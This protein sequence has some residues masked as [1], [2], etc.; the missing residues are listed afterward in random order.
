[1]K[2]TQNIIFNLKQI[3]TTNLQIDYLYQDDEVPWYISRLK[4][5]EWFFPKAP[6]PMCK[7]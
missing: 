3:D 1:M 7:N 5:Q 6:N 4:Y 2:Q